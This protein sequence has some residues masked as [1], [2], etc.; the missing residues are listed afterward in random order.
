LSLSS[1]KDKAVAKAEAK[2]K[3]QKKKSSR[4]TDGPYIDPVA[5]ARTYHNAGKGDK[6]RDMDGW[7]SDDVTN[8]LEKIYGKKDWKKKAEQKNSSKKTR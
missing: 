3:R 5:E 6:I 8:T 2:A 1:K 7:F 4:P